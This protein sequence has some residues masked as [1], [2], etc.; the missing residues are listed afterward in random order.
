MSVIAVRF[1]EDITK[2]LEK[3]STETERP[4]SFYVRKLVEENLED[5]ED[6]YLLEQAIEDI[7]NGKDELI[8]FVKE[9][10][11]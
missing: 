2:R 10:Y 6:R 5:I 8:P 1:N 11:L 3:L 7:A 4:K 9:D